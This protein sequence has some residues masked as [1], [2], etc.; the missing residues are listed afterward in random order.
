MLHNEN[1]NPYEAP[2]SEPTPAALA[3]APDARRAALWSRLLKYYLRLVGVLQFLYGLIFGAIT[4]EQVR[5]AIEF[6]LDLARPLILFAVVMGP[7][8]AWLTIAGLIAGIQTIRLRPSSRVWQIIYL[9]ACVSFFGGGTVLDWIVRGSPARDL[10]TTLAFFITFTLPYI[11]LT[12]V[13]H[14]PRARSSD[15]VRDSRQD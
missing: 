15:F 11:P 14:W 10:A 7:I 5:L 6:R 4:Y 13:T 9:G 2:A 12:F 3:I 8:C 1:D